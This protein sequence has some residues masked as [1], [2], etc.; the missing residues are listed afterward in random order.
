MPEAQPL[1]FCAALADPLLQQPALAQEW[2]KQ[3]VVGYLL[4]RIFKNGPF[5]VPTQLQG[6]IIP[7]H[8]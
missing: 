4:C 2:L 7:I 5:L 3:I 6:I 8:R 1:S